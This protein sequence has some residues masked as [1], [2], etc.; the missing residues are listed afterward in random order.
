MGAG[1]TLA[2]MS[3]NLVT[4]TRAECEAAFEKYGIDRKKFPVAM[5]A[6]R[7]HLD[8]GKPGNDVGVYD[9]AV[10]VVG[11]GLFL[12]LKSNTDPSRIGWNPGVGKPFAQLDAPQVCYFIF[13]LHKGQYKALRQPDE[14]QARALG[15]PNKGHFTVCRD[16]NDGKRKPYKE[17]G[18][19]A[20]NYHMGGQNGTSSWGCQTMPTETYWTFYNAVRG[21]CDRA[22]QKVVPYLL[23]P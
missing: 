15:I 10:A 21:A 13:G 12:A 5:M 6:D 20:I 23:I 8:L 9:D 4:L 3:A 1:A 19:F 18:Y 7:A 16:P 11:P 2:P 17:T 22:G 14:D